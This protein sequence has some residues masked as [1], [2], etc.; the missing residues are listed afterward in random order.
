M[1]ETYVGGDEEGVPGRQT[2]D[3]AIVVVAA[4][5]DGRGIGRI[6]LRR[7]PDVSG[8]SLQ[9]CIEE[10]V[11][12]GSVVH[13]DGWKVFGATASAGA[14]AR[15]SPPK[16]GSWIALCACGWRWMRGEWLTAAK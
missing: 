13:T 12:P 16:S 15:S 2:E 10:S 7:V 4:E 5:Q 1:D 9:A 6:R 3:Q 11:T 8:D 14:S